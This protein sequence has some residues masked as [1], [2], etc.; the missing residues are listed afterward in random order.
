M[1]GQA[2][3]A[4]ARTGGFGAE[5]GAKGGPGWAESPPLWRNKDE[6]EGPSW[7]TCA[8]H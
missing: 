1:L 2:P 3:A 4:L 7:N 5:E 6:R 8:S